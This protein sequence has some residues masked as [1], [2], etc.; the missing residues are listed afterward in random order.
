MSKQWRIFVVED[1]ES[2]N[3]NIVNSL[4][5]KYSVKSARS[6]ADAAST[7]RSEEYDVVVCDLKTTGT[8]GFELLQWI[9]VYRPQVRTIMVGESSMR[10]QALEK[11]AVGYL[12]K[13]LNIQMLQEE[14]H[15]LLQQ[16]GFSANLESFDLLDVIQIINM[17]RKSIVLLVNT[18]LEEQGVLR[19]QNGELS[20]AEYGIL[21]GEEAFFALAAYKNGTVIQ[22]E[23]NEQVTPNVRQSL[24]RL[25]LQALQYREKYAEIQQASGKQEAVPTITSL[26]QSDQSPFA[27]MV[28]A[29]TDTPTQ[30][31]SSAMNTEEVKELTGS[32]GA[33]KEW[34]QLT[35]KTA[36]TKNKISAFKVKMSTVPLPTSPSNG[37]DDVNQTAVTSHTDLPSWLTDQPTMVE[38]PAVNPS[39]DTNLL[40]RSTEPPTSPEW[41][42]TGVDDIVR[43]S[44]PLLESLV[45]AHKISEPL[46]HDTPA[47]AAS[48][49]FSEQEPLVKSKYNYTALVS[50]L[51]TVGYAISGFLAAA[52]VS[53]DGQTMAHVA[54]DDLDIAEMGTQF[55]HILQSGLQLDQG[56]WGSHEHTVITQAHRHIL[57]RLIG[58]EKNVFQVLI[59]TRQANTQHSLEIMANA[60][61]AISAALH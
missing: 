54:A 23:W 4:K 43:L 16:T 40:L 14:L 20:W 53:L 15:R 27:L 1:D 13:P 24:S 21:K 45:T 34:W 56:V 42:P 50:A 39:T 12:E 26:E 11:G 44:G 52:V 8:D 48:Y 29:L 10:M 41:Q 3:R 37:N 59:T 33:T 38:I 7:L 61:S 6:I 60:E 9:R 2:L 30:V 18:G 28:E 58:S 22:Q 36:A 5:E 19:F 25:I 46:S 32:N 51:Q 55:G 57:L 31:L 47:D 35:G 49:S 17:S